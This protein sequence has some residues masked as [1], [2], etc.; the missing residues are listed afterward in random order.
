MEVV[1]YLSPYIPGIGNIADPLLEDMRNTMRILL[2]RAKIV[3]PTSKHHN[4]KRDIF[5]RSGKIEKIGT[6]LDVK[7]SQIID[8]NNL[9][10]STGWCDI[11]C[12]IGEPGYEHR[13]TIRSFARAA[14]AGGYT[15]TACFANTNPA[16]DNS[17]PIQY[18]ISGSRDTAIDILPIG[19]ITTGAKG[20]EI[21]ELQDMHNSGAVAF[22][23][24]RYPLAH[25]GI[26]KLA[27]HYVKTFN[28]LVINRPFDKD[29]VS[30]GQMHEGLMSTSLGMNGFP[31]IA[32]R[33]VLERDLRLLEYA[34]SRLHAF[35]ISSAISVNLIAAARKSG[36]HVSTSV[37]ALNL[38]FTDKK[39]GDFGTN[40]KV[41]PPLREEKDRL[42][43]ING[44]RS[45]TIEAISSNHEPLEE[46][47]KKL[48]F[49]NAGFGSTGLQTAFALANTALHDKIEL[50]EIIH[51]FSTGPRKILGLDAISISEG[52]P[53]VLTLF[54]PD[55][56]WTPTEED[57][58]SKSKNSAALNIQLKGRA[59]GIVNKKTIQTSLDK[60]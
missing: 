53:A 38:L 29:L 25:T 47:E 57:L 50:E 51:C 26:M 17:S 60:K 42:A 36:L 54:D 59:L 28:G 12:Q 3:D 8:Y 44:I 55:A 14:A 45:G 7:A 21:A 30:S 18:V 48:E 1:Y 9:H 31:H 19:A 33:I 2:K 15:T 46:E 13:E 16:L 39:L 11:G 52:M 34:E 6:N 56:T 32:E 43:L 58:L 24:G 4:K 5:I 49:A 35:G 41:M 40:F 27:L 20:Q 23:D 10:V 37:P 22:S